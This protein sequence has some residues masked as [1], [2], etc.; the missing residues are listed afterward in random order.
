MVAAVFDFWYE[1]SVTKYTKIRLVIV[2][3]VLNVVV[4]KRSEDVG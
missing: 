3:L 1:Y 2:N 4:A